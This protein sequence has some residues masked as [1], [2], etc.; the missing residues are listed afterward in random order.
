V[1]YFGWLE[2][3]RDATRRAII[4]CNWSKMILASAS[5]TGRVGVFEHVLYHCVIL[6]EGSVS[7]Q[8]VGFL[9]HLEIQFPV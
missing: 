5:R 8:P 3:G 6:P 1:R 9:A 4:F 7:R 2:C